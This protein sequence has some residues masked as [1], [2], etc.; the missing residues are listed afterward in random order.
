MSTTNKK[1]GTQPRKTLF[2]MRRVY[3]FILI[4][5]AALV[6]IAAGLAIG[7]WSAISPKVPPI[8]AVTDYRP[9]IPLRIYTADKVLI[10]QFG[11]EHRDFVPIAKIPAM[12]K[13][14]VLAIE[15]TRF[16][17]HGGI[18]FIRALGAAR[19]NLRGGF[20]QGASTI[21]MQVARNFFL[22]NEK[23]VSR[24]LTEIALAYKIE[25]SL[26]K[27]QILE[28]YMNQIYLGQRSYGF[29]SAARSYFGKTLDALSLA[30][31]AMLAG[32]P[33]NPARTNPVTNPKRA[34]AR[35]HAILKRL[36][37]LGEITEP[38][39]RQALAEPLRIKRDAGQTFDTPAQYVAELA[40]QT[41]YEQ[42]GEEA[43]TRGIVVTTTIRAAE[44]KAA[45]ESVRRNVLAYDG[46][47]GYREIGRAHV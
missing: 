18:D 24:K 25:D 7:V 20:R 29:S 47:H 1:S 41:V 37:E 35:Q 42:F 13:N 21:T 31:T 43:Y 40:R 5:C 45:Y 22:T 23:T 12:M 33:Q 34:Q 19:A 8:D 28:L 17:E 46:R 27:D 9:K 26:S 16:Y 14:A 6:L 10:G 36:L 3:A 11:V 44:Q 2:G 32:L 30:E 39:Y 4:A 15:D 38:Q